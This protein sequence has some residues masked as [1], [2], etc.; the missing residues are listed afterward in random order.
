MHVCFSYNK[1]QRYPK[2]VNVLSGQGRV[3]VS[4]ITWF[5][6]PAIAEEMLTGIFH[7]RMVTRDLITLWS[8]DKG[9]KI[10]SMWPHVSWTNF[11][12]EAP[13][14]NIISPCKSYPPWIRKVY[15]IIRV[16]MILTIPASIL[17]CKSKV[18]CKSNLNQIP[19]WN[20]RYQE[21]MKAK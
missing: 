8:I 1:R 19:V 15:S 20:S 4:N 9:T 21:H 3:P 14:L 2:M 10:P 7:Y 5:P 6:H 11:L 16:S 13:Y 18:Y 12:Q 17:K